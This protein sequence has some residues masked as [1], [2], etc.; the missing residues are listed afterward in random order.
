MIALIDYG[1]GNIQSVL[2]ALRHEGA[3]VELVSTPERLAAAQG[4]VLPGVG[5]FGDCVRGLQSRHLWEP[6]QEWLESGKPFFGICVGYQLLFDESEESPGVRGFGHF[7][8]V[9]KKFNVPGLKVPQIGWNNLELTNP[10]DPLWRGLP[11]NPHVYFVHSYFPAPEDETIITSRSTHGET[12]AASV[13]REN[14]AA[15]QFHPEKSQ[16]V[17]LGIL[18]NFISTTH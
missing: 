9:V 13:A 2:N 8:G 14:V 3:D 15:V 4:V 7:K 1:S 11:A 12:F 17:G 16:A 18:R 6:V 10:A 5:A